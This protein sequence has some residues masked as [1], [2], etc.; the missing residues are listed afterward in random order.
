M[1]AYSIRRPGLALWGAWLV[2]GVAGSL[3]PVLPAAFNLRFPIVAGLSL[4]HA[5]GLSSALVG[6]TCLALFQTIVLGALKARFSASVLM[7]IPVSTGATV[8]AYLAIALWQVTVPRTV[9]SVS[10]IGASLPPGFPLLQVIFALFGIAVAVV[11]GLAQG[12]LLA[13]V[14]RRRS[15]VG[16]WFG[17]QSRRGSLG[18]NRFWDPTHGAGHRQRRRPDGHCLVEHAN[19]CCALRRRDGCGTCCFRSARD[20]GLRA[21]PSL[22]P[23]GA[24]ARRANT[25]DIASR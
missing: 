18:G 10:A 2:A 1:M 16:L 22:V 21:G 14:L 8:V 17:C 23:A 20:R 5:S 12:M 19:R 13:R 25:S 3:L 6:A 11:V 7:W 9:I 24:Y 4:D 15:A